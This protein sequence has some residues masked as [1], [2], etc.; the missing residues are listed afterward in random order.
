MSAL[1]AWLNDD[2]AATRG[3]AVAQNAWRAWRRFASNPLGL[4]G[5]AVVLLLVGTALFAPWIATH[6][7]NDQN[8]AARLMAPSAAHWLGTDE[9]GRDIW[10]RLVWGS[11]ITLSIIAIVSIV[12]APIGLAVGCVAGYAGGWAD[13][14]LMRVTDLFLAFP[15]LIL[16]LAFV[17]ALG[18]SLENAILAIALTQW[19]PIARLA[20]AETLSLRNSDYIAAVRLLG[21]SP[22]RIVL[23]HVTPLCLPSVVVRVTLNMASIILTAAG[24]GFL[25]LGAQPPTPEWGAM[26]STGRRFMLDSWWV[27][28]FPGVAILVVSLAFNLVGDALRDALDP[29]QG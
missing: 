9:L 4:I 1:A 23:R 2:V 3:Q 19:P 25:G 24:L 11:R 5:L 22:A 14:V 8:L 10:S 13:A 29:R 20:R 15:S 12:V 27:V 6:P 28:T 16:A 18:P 7:P 17:A 26:V 21:A